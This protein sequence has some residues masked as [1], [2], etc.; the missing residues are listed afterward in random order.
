MVEHAQA[1]GL[2]LFMLFIDLTQAFDRVLREL[3][4]GWP[5][6]SSLDQ[7]TYDAQVVYIVSLGVARATAEKIVTHVRD[8]GDVLSQWDVDPLVAELVRGLHTHALRTAN[9]SLK[10]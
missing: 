6:G 9:P 8:H 2:S 3:A 1:A 5:Q 4:F 7:A 10:R